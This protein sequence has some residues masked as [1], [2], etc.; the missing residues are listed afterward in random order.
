MKCQDCDSAIINGIPCHEQG[1]P[2]NHIDLATGKP[3]LIPCSWCGSPV[4]APPPPYDKAFCDG[5]CALAY[6][7][8]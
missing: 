7:G 5:N 4:P 8:Y 6:L 2:S 3:Y 1:C